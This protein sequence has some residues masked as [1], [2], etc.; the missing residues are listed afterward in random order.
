MKRA[1][2]FS[3]SS[4]LARR[5]NGQIDYRPVESSVTTAKRKVN[6]LDKN[7]K[8]RIVTIV[9]LVALGYLYLI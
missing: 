1:E 3:Y 4:Q 5:I 9:S 2:H 6:E 8:I 7:A